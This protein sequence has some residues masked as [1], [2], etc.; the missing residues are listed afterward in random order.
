MEPPG[1]G[2]L[3]AFHSFQIDRKI[4]PTF[5]ICIVYI[6]G[7]SATYVLASGDTLV[8]SCAVAKDID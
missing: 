6:A 7:A 4:Y 1:G 8:Q 5:G 3:I 2:D